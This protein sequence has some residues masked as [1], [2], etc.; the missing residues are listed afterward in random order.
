[1]RFSSIVLRGLLAGALAAGA[2]L[3]AT[4]VPIAGK[5][6]LNYAKSNF[7]ET[8]LTY[9]ALPTGEWSSTTAGQTY[10]FRMDGKEY[11]DGQ[12]NTVGWKSLDPNTWQ[13]TWMTN[14]RVSNTDTLR[15]GADGILTESQKGVKPDGG[16]IENM[17]TFQRVSGGPGLAG[18]W[19]TKNMQSATDNVVEFTA[20]DGNRLAYNE[21]TMG[22]S[23]DSKVDGK[24]YACSGAMIPKGWSIAMTRSGS[25]ALTVAIKRDNKLM[26]RYIY[27]VSPDGKTLTATGAATGTREK[28]TMVYDRE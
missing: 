27:N 15:L 19:K 6:K 5:W 21:H 7:G 28:V 12:G 1:M 23:C 9:T 25:R 3:A 26:Y 16:T 14:G 20:G 24:D 4:D 18:K 11:S 17:I 10:K 13:S 8:T 2:A 22:V